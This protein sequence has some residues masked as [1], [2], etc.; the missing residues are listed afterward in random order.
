MASDAPQ[1]IKAAYEQFVEE[2]PALAKLKLVL[3]LELQGRGDVQFFRVE[4][5]GPEIKKIDPDDARLE[6]SMPR[7]VLN[8]HAHGTVS[9][10][11]KP[12]DHGDIKVGGDPAIAKLLGTVISKHESRASHRRVS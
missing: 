7:A 11:H 1:L 6:I 9:D 2:L 12:W 8:E 10:W 4:A 5:P 3:K